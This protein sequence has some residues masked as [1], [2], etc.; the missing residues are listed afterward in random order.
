MRTENS[1]HFLLSIFF[2][3]TKYL[4]LFIVRLIHKSYNSAPRPSENYFR[5]CFSFQSE[6]VV[7]WFCFL[8][9]K[10]NQNSSSIERKYYHRLQIESSRFLI[11]E[12]SDSLPQKIFCN[13]SYCLEGWLYCVTI[14]FSYI[15]CWRSKLSSWPFDSFLLFN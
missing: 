3:L 13:N 8:Y 9:G 1:I 7:S 12:F 2:P 15:T 6:T 10:Q 11:C 14:P 5:F 4:L